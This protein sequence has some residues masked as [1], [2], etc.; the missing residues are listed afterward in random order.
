M[1]HLSQKWRK[2]ILAVV[3]SFEEF[4]QQRVRKDIERLERS[5]PPGQSIHFPYYKMLRSF[6][7]LRNTSGLSGVQEKLL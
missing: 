5:K 7:E 3:L 2:V 1:L 4:V 6:F